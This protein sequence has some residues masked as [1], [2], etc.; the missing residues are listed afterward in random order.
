MLGGH[1]RRQT[2]RESKLRV[3]NELQVVQ[4]E[5]P[6]PYIYSSLYIFSFSWDLLTVTQFSN[7]EI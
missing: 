2:R 5:T 7:G 6:F 1:L 3:V 4:E